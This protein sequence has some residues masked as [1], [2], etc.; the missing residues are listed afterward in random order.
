MKRLK[1]LFI[2]FLSLSLTG[3]VQKYNVTDA[4][5]DATAEYMAGLLLKYDKDYEQDLAPIENAA[6]D[7]ITEEESSNT[8]DT[9]AVNEVETDNSSSS[10]ETLNDYT[11]TQVIGE[12]G[13]S[14]NYKDYILVDTYPEEPESASFSLTPREGYQLL[15]ASFTIKNTSDNEKEI[16]LIRSGITYQLSVNNRS[17]YE[18]LLTLLEN[19]LRYFDLTIAAGKSKKA[20]LIF[21]VSNEYGYY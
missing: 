21:E 5:S 11:L 4:Q 17:I 18:P 8:S 3:C 1:F 9:D 10:D 12:S 14:I 2:L 13:F 19:D 16:N 7:S 20:L 6:D 15:V